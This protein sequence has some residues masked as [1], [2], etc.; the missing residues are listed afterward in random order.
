M[1]KTFSE[2]YKSACMGQSVQR[3]SIAPDDPFYNGMAY[4]FAGKEV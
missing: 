2:F 4:V 3:G 1:L